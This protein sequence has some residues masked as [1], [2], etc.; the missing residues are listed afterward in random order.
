MQSEIASKVADSLGVVLGAGTEK[1]LSERPTAN[2]AAY[3]AFLKGEQ[4]SMAMAISEPTR[5]RKALPYYEA[6]VAQDPAFAQGWARVSV[7]NSLLYTNG[8]P[9]PALVER[10]RGAAEKAIGLAPLRWEG[11]QAL[12]NFHRMVSHDMGLAREQYSKGL[13]IAPTEVSLLSSSAAAEAAIGLW[14]SAQEHASQAVRLDPRNAAAVRRLGEIFLLTR[15]YPEAREHFDRALALS[16]TA[17]N[18]IEYRA[19]TFLGQGDLAGARGSLKSSSGVVDPAALVA[20][21]AQYRDLPWVL[22]DEQQALL[23]RLP[24]SAFDDDVGSWALCLA[25]TYAF[26]HDAANM[27]L[28]A[29]T[30]RKGYEDQLRQNPND[31]QR[32]ALLGLA[33]AYLGRKDEAI[34]EGLRSLE[35][36]PLTKDS[37]NY[38]YNQHQLARIYTLV[39]EP[40][41]ALDQLESLLRM[42]YF[43][44]PAWLKI[45]PNFE[46]LR[47]NPRFQ[48]LTGSSS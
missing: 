10:A 34:R 23:L 24:A 4:E 41:K 13:H 28:H 8:I 19:M 25:Q 2:V 30:T 11:Y 37:T 48:K 31:D 7:G 46:A 22:D 5:L 32:H 39:G 21:V 35:L 16:P 47:K 20:Y 12:G 45:D 18:T 15:R 42:P 26:K 27:R 33:L 38:T 17:L 6:A 43:L 44:S 29:E 14:D 40:E 9:D 1:R 3:D 36:M